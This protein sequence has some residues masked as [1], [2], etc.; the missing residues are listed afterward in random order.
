M[1]FSDNEEKLSLHYIIGSKYDGHGP[2]DSVPSYL[3]NEEAFFRFLSEN[4]SYPINASQ[5]KTEGIVEISLLVDTNGVLSDFIIENGIGN[6]CEE[7]A[8]R[9]IKLTSGNWSPA[10]YNGNAIPTRVLCYI[11]FRLR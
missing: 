7:E 9:V 3:P 11:R 10:F 1:I 2:I 6:G 8:I 4:I 5:N